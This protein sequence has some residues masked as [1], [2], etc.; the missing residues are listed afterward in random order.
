MTME[1]KDYYLHTY[2][3]VGGENKHSKINSYH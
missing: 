3:S 1:K 2:R